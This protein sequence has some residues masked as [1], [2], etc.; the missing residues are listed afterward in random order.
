MTKKPSIFVVEDDQW[1]A[2]HY[3]RVLGA[4]GY[5]V[6]FV[7]SAI[8]A[9]D[10]IDTRLPDLIILDVLLTGQNAFTLLHEL[11]SHSDLARIPI[12]LCTNTAEEIAEEDIAIYGV[13]L[14]LDKA[15]MQPSD[16]VKAVTKVLL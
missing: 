8:D 10:A 13:R 12:I 11:R 5:T 15:T 2:E 14:L 1:L 7:T 3:E 4:A 6:H 9:I 16:L